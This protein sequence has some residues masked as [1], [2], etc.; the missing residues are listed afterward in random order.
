VNNFRTILVFLIFLFSVVFSHSATAQNAVKVSPGNYVGKWS[1]LGVTGTKSG[2][3]N[4]MLNAGAYIVQVGV[5]LGHVRIEVDANGVVESLNKDAML[6]GSLSLTFKTK[7]VAIDPGDY[8]GK[9]YV[10]S[11]TDA[12]QGSQSVSLVPNLGYIVQ[13]GV[14]IGQVSINID[15]AGEVTSENEDAMLGGSLSLTFKTKKVAIDP[16]DYAGKWYVLSVTDAMQ[17]SQSVSLVPNLGYIVQVGVHIGRVSINIDAA[18]GVTSVNEDAMLGGSLSLTFKTAEV[19][20]DPTTYGDRWYVLNVTGEKYGEQDVILVCNLSY[21]L[22]GGY[23]INRE[24]FMVDSACSPKPSVVPIVIN[25]TSHDF[26]LTQSFSLVVGIDIKPG[27]TT[28]PVNP[29][30]NGKIR[31]AILSAP[32]F[33][34][35]DV[36]SSSVKFGRTGTEVNGKPEKNPRDLNHDRVPDIV[37]HFSLAGGKTGIRC[38]D[39]SASLTGLTSNN[40]AIFASDFITTVGQG[41]CKR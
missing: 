41:G 15:A 23:S 18:G 14:H 20:I 2:P 9:W 13:V 35:L 31:V 6:G 17:G 7:Q 10:L 38:G 5:H 37:F 39:I 12:M 19:N 21:I 4:V 11:V 34:P 40:K 1:I 22:Q 25:G 36:V 24:N 8:F 28:N 32:G 27:S 26:K 29:K 33:R 16:G 3:A 30:S